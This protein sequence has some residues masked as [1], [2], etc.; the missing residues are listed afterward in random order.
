[1]IDEPGEF[2]RGEKVKERKSPN[3]GTTTYLSILKSGPLDC[4]FSRPAKIPPLA[5]GV[6]S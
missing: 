6:A 4:E 3:N 5:R 2:L 1:M